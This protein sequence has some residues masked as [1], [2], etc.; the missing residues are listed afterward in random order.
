MVIEDKFILMATW[1][2]ECALMRSDTG[3]GMR[4]RGLGFKSWKEQDL[5]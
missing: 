4:E 5:W 3:V 1:G 2:Q